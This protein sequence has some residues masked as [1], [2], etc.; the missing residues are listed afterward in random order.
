MSNTPKLAPG[1]HECRIVSIDY[2]KHEDFMTGCLAAL[3]KDGTVMIEHV[4]SL[5]GMVELKPHS[6]A[7]IIN[8]PYALPRKGDRHHKRKP[9]PNRGPVGRNQW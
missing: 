9:Q 2:A 1:L 4:W 3:S 7:D 6:Y 8:M 5:P